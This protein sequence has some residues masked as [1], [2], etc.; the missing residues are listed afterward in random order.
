MSFETIDYSVRDN[1]A[2]IILNRPEAAN[3][4]NR[5]LGYDL[6]MASIDCDEN[7]DVRAVVLSGA[8]KMF[9]AGGDLKFFHGKGDAL[10]AAMKELTVYLHGAVSRFAR[11]DAPVIVAVNGTAAGAGM[12][13]AVCGDLVYAAQSAKFTMAYTAAGLSPDG[14]STYFLPRLIGLRRTQELVLTNRVLSADEALDWGMVTGVHSDDALMG[15][16]DEIA[17]SLA[18]GAT[19]SYGLAKRL[20]TESFT[21]PLETQMELEARGITDAARTRDGKH[22]IDAFVNKRKPDFTAE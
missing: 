19:K 17:K 15:N 21:N 5:Q 10:P 3:S 4:L 6:M 8:G 18:S 2:R 12:S 9:C 16:V 14:S 13:L 7:P 1:V 20:L 11:M 22:G